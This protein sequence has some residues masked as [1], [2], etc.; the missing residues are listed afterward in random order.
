MVDPKELSDAEVV[1]ELRELLGGKLVAYMGNVRD[2][3][4]IR[5]WATDGAER[6]PS[7][8][9][10]GLRLALDLTHLLLHWEHPEVIQAWFIGMNPYLDDVAAATLIRDHGDE[11]A[12]RIRA[13]ARSFL[14]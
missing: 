6:P 12:S 10:P 11:H 4:T 1:R 9:M 2:T 8:V 3:A 5:R 13:A 7:E 14:G